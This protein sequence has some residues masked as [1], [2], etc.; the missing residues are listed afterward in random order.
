[1]R[2]M[3]KSMRKYIIEFVK[4]GLFFGSFG[5][6]IT[7]IVFWIIDC[8]VG[9]LVLSGS[10][11]LLAIVSTY[12]LAFVQAGASIFNQIE[13]WPL[14]KSL[15]CHMGAIYLVYVLCYILNS[16]IP[17]EPVVILIFTAVFAATYFTIWFTVYF[18]V[19]AT[20]RRFNKKIE[21]M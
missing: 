16:W 10:E 4:R 9:G 18:I 8:T 7:G 11:V 14:A 12:V 6:V 15:L 2:G 3:V 17:F 1:M 20:E 21:N 19:R 13:N 5:P